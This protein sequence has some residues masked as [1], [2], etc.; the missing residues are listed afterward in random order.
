MAKIKAIANNYKKF[1]NEKIK[2]QF[3]DFQ[4]IFNLVFFNLITLFNTSSYGTRR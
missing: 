3:T 1:S 2:F 4:I